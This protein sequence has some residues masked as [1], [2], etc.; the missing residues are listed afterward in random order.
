MYDKLE[1]ND[2]LIS[3]MIAGGARYDAPDTRHIEHLIA[4]RDAK[5]DAAG[6]EPGHAFSPLAWLTARLAPKATVSASVGGTASAA[7]PA[8]STTCCAPD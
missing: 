7:M 4:L 2:P 5:R 1:R 8:A 3:W 6:S